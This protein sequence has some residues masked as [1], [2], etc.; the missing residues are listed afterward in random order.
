MYVYV[1]NNMACNYIYKDVMV[2]L[3]KGSVY[4]DMHV[5]KTAVTACISLY[6]YQN[7]CN[8]MYV[9]ELFDTV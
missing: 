2:L 9:Y 5:T 3:F 6:V 8:N 7:C 4:S 1:C